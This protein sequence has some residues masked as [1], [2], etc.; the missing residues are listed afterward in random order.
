MDIS[1][2]IGAL[3]AKVA[4]A[5]AEHDGAPTTTPVHIM[6]AFDHMSRAVRQE[7]D[8]VMTHREPVAPA[9]VPEPLSHDTAGTPTETIVE[10]TVQEEAQKT[11]ASA[12][13]SVVEQAPAVVVAE[14]PE[15]AS[16]V[17]TQAPAVEIASAGDPA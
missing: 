13:E 8:R 17:V 16:E 2:E 12:P 10:E 6:A 14:A 4:G 5:F 7:F 3:F 1:A 15:P 11:A 9:V